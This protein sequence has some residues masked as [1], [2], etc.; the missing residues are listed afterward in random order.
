[1]SVKQR[2]YPSPEQVAVFRMHADHARFLY[3]LG[4]DQRQRWVRSKH[5]RSPDLNAARVNVATQMRELTELRRE[6]DWLAAGSTIVQQG[7]LRD[8]DRAYSNFFAGRADRPTFKRRNDRTGSFVV[9]DVRMKRLNRRWAQI[10]V[11]KAGPVKFRITRGWH[12]IRTATSARVTLK[13][14]R[15][16]VSLTTSVPAKIV[17]GTGAVVGIDRGVANTYAT[18]D[19]EFAHMPDW[20]P[21]E[22]ARFMALERQLARQT[23][24][25]KKA[26]RNIHTEAASRAKTLDRL[27]ALRRKLDDRRTNWIEQETTR[28]ARTYDIVVLENLT[29]SNMVRRPKPKPD[30]DNAGAFLPNR[31]KAKAAL[32]RAIHA[33][34]WAEFAT[35][36]GHKTTVIVVPAAYT[37]QTCRKCGHIS[38]ENRESQAVFACTRCGHTNH[39]DIN[40]ALNILHRGTQLSPEP[41]DIGGSPAQAHPTGGRRNQPEAAA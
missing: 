38:S 25:A 6:L 14:G 37:S 2:M 26:G 27:A 33:S 12:H 18:S 39:A 4:L 9:R 40:A 36:L 8:L 32:N 29:V 7:A 24:A 28:L 15:W 19:G 11:P 41:E 1:M 3:N 22:R 30:P 16:H 17:A 35:R 13:N 20:T 10:V 21:G 34:R 5:D 23:R 31:A